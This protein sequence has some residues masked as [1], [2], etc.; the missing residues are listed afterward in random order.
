MW[1]NDF[2]SLPFFVTLLGIFESPSPPSEF[3]LATFL[4][5]MTVCGQDAAVVIIRA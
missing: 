1:E 3:R 5:P 2:Q 4:R